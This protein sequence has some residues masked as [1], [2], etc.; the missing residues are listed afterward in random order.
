MGTACSEKEAINHVVSNLRSKHI[1]AIF[2]VMKQSQKISYRLWS[3]GAI[4]IRLSKGAQKFRTKQNPT[5]A[6]GGVKQQ[7]NMQSFGTKN[8]S[9]QNSVHGPSAVCEVYKHVP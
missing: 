2:E 5:K 9:S 3:F 6:T 1:H 7:I 4:I 8:R